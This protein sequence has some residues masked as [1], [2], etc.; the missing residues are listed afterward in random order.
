MDIVT[1]I[2]AFV[3]GVIAT[4]FVIGIVQIIIAEKSWIRQNKKQIV[5]E[6]SFATIIFALFILILYFS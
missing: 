1:C 6:I 2:F 3:A 4:I 5:K